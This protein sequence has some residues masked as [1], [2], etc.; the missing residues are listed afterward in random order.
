[1]KKRAG[2]PGSKKESGEC[3][4]PKRENINL[5][6]LKQNVRKHGEVNKSVRKEG[7]TG[8][9]SCGANEPDMRQAV[10]QGSSI[11]VS[12][13][14]IDKPHRRTASIQSDK[15]STPLKLKFSRGK[16][17]SLQSENQAPRILKF[18][19]A[20][21]ASDKQNAKGD[22]DTKFTVVSKGQIDRPHRRTASVHLE[23]KISTPQK[24]KF[25]RGKVTSL[26]PENNV[27]RILR[28]RRRKLASD[29]QNDQGDFHTKFLRSGRSV[30]NSNASLAKALVV[31]LKHQDV[32]EK[33][34]TQRLLNQ[35]IE[36]TASKLVE[37]R[38]SKVKALVG[39]FETVI[40]LHEGKLS[41]PPVP[42]TLY[43]A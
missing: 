7:N 12:K 18:R 9:K 22:V 11:V 21:I 32:Q 8:S 2:K 17:V 28:F 24:L 15:L 25:S 29:N 30:T 3:S 42:P 43:D 20:K 1:M 5:R 38:K 10:A 39:A 34:D 37:T 26:Q 13:D 27:P 16:V 6:S 36:E 33:K 35:M 41:P 14:Q 40:S 23:E 19:Q 4:G 31:V